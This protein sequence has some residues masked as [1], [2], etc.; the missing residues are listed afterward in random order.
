MGATILDRKEIEKD[1]SD[2][3]NNLSEKEK[4]VLRNRV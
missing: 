3:L 2:I 4:N 1:F